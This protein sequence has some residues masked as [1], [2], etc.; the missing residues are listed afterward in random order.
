MAVITNAGTGT[1]T[2]SCKS[3]VR[4]YV[5]N[6]YLEAK[7]ANE[8]GVSVRNIT[9]QTI[10]RV[11]SPYANSEGVITKCEKESGVKGLRIDLQK[12]QNGYAYWQVQWGTGSSKTGGAFAGVLMKVDTDFTMLD[13]RTALESSFNYT[14]VKYARLDPN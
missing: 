4:D 7:I 3:S 8:M 1:F 5:L 13:L 6:T 11:N 10:V 12:E 9:D 2:P 14:P